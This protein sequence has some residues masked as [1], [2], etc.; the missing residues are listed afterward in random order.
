MGAVSKKIEVV[1]SEEEEEEEE[2]VAKPVLSGNT[3]SKPRLDPEP[4][5]SNRINGVVEVN[6]LFYAPFL[7]CN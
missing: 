2:I 3:T 4:D 6:E 1:A 5:G 7:V